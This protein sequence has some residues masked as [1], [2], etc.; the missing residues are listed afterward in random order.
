[1][2]HENRMTVSQQ[3][4]RQLAERAVWVAAKHGTDHATF[5]GPV[6]T[7]VPAAEAYIKVYD[8][9]VTARANQRGD[10]EAGRERLADLWREVRA[11]VAAVR[12]A[13]PTFDASELTGNVEKPESLFSDGNKLIELISTGSVTHGEGI[14]ALLKA[15]LE[16]AKPEW[17]NAQNARVDLQ[18]KQ[19]E[20]RKHAAVLN[21]ELVG[22]RRV[23]ST[24]L[25]T[26]HLA[27]Q[28]LRTSRVAS[29]N[30]IDEDESVVEDSEDEPVALPAISNGATTNGS[31][32]NGKGH[33]AFN[34]GVIA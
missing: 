22:L 12:H 15:A 18:A 24:V 3:R 11:A 28:T 23:L 6:A 17:E 31:N 10:M 34:L 27:Y 30:V 13:I 4:L 8:E 2:K 25:G 29:P 19:A 7:V 14:V 32:T 5:A 33:T 20:V 9:A 16:K 26:S 1:M 21:Q